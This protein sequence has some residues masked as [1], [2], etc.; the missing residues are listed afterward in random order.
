MT[1]RVARRV[2]EMFSKL[3]PARQDYGLGPREREVLELYVRGL[4]N[5]EIA[6]KLAEESADNA[7]YVEPSDINT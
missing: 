1:P 7:H 2:L 3:A 4:T 6:D 5:K